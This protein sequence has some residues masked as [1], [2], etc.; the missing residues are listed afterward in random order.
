MRLLKSFLLLLLLAAASAAQNNL[1]VVK[2]NVSVI[3]IQ[4][5]ETLKKDSWTLGPETKPDVYEADLVGGK[6]RKVTF[7]TDVDSISFTVEE[8]KQY[9][10]IIRR[11][12][13]FCHTR[14]VGT[15]FC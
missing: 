6:P 12:E 5:G 1:P 2:S 15:G 3:S 11:G 10:F 9:D 13:D 14:I 8:G 4:D 7:I